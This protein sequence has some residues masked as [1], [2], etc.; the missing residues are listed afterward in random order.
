MNSFR[1]PGN[2]PVVFKWQIA[3]SQHNDAA[4]P[5]NATVG[6]L[7]YQV[8]CYFIMRYNF[9]VVAENIIFYVFLF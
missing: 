8:P 4:T 3:H 9:E 1:L 5:S 2:V 7:F 6:A